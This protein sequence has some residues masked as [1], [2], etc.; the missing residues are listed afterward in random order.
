[1]QA[2]NPKSE[3]AEDVISLVSRAGIVLHASPSTARVFGFSPEEIVGRNVLD[4][5]HRDDRTPLRR[6]AMM[7]L[8]KSCA[9]RLRIRARRKNGEWFWAESTICRLPDEYRPGTIFVNCREIDA[10]DYGGERQDRGGLLSANA[11]LEQFAWSVAHD[12]REPLRTISIYTQL[13]VKDTELDGQG[14]VLAR[15]VADG[16]TC[17]SEL[18]EGLHSFATNG[19]DRSSQSLDLG[20]VVAEVL[21]DL[22]HDLNERRHRDCQSAA[23]RARQQS[24]SR[25]NLPESDRQRDQVSRSGASEDSHI[26]G[27]KWIVRIK[28]MA[29]V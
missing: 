4:V 16:V 2:G 18:F 9:R 8:S 7:V 13:L 15:C 3:G 10:V 25:E 12:L 26:R 1:M 29:S 21:Q 19:V 24:A 14:R 5:I 17:L 20:L 27:T 11:R 6:A 22:T 28:D 23:C